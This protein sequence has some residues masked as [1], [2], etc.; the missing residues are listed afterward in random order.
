[1]N[2]TL[3]HEYTHDFFHNLYV[4]ADG[5]GESKATHNENVGSYEV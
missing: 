3:C 5:G 4:I 2:M 1:M